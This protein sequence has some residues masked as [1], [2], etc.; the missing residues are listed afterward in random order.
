MLQPRLYQVRHLRPDGD[1]VGLVYAR[2]T[3][4]AN[5]QVRQMFGPAY[6]AVAEAPAKAPVIPGTFTAGQKA[7]FT[8]QLRSL[9]GV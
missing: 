5:T 4:S 9:A 6:V 1:Q 2:S 3:V 7:A 8:K